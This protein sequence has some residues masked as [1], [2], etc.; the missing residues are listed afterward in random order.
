M[1]ANFKC[2]GDTEDCTGPDH[3]SVAYIRLTE[4]DYE[5]VTY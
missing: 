5:Y 4:K 1:V 2:V 3:T